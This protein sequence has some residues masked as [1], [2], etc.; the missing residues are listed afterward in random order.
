MGI[1]LKQ[2]GVDDFAILE[3]A[4]AMF[5]LA[6][7]RRRGKAKRKAAEVAGA[8]RSSQLSPRRRIGSAPCPTP[9]PSTSRS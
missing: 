4:A 1:G 6:L 8:F 9:M 3:R 2:I 5:L 7:M